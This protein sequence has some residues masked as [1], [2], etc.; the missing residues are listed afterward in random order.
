MNIKKLI[1]ERMTENRKIK[2]LRLKIRHEENI[3]IARFSERTRAERKRNYIKKG[4]FWGTLARD[5]STPHRKKTLNS[6]D[7]LIFGVSKP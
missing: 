7:H 2:A 1:K 4:G 6:V 5:L 3:K